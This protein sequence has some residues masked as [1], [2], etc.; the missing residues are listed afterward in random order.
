MSPVLDTVEYEWSRKGSRIV[1]R[2]SYHS[3]LDV[4][5]TLEEGEYKYLQNKGGDPRL[6]VKYPRVTMSWDSKEKKKI[7]KVFKWLYV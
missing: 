4:F 5:D 6:L 3:W 2:K 1:P 7:K